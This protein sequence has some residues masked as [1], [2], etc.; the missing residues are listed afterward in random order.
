M[1]DLEHKPMNHIILGQSDMSKK[2]NFTTEQAKAKLRAE[3][4]ELDRER[5]ELN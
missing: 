1:H 4:E 3:L 5:R 2:R